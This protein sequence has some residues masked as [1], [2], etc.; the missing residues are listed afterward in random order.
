[1]LTFKISEKWEHRIRRILVI[2]M[3]I[4]AFCF[5]PVQEVFIPF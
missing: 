2:L 5:G 4:A 3:F 1:M